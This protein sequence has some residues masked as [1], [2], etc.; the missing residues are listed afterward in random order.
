[1]QYQTENATGIKKY[2]LRIL[3]LSSF[4]IVTT[5]IGY[6]IYLAM[7]STAVVISI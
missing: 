3:P 4:R 6:F 5:H 1:M 2:I 7:L